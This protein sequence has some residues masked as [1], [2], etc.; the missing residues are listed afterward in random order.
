[1][2][3]YDDQMTTRAARVVCSVGS[4]LSVGS[5][6]V[7]CWPPSVMTLC[8]RQWRGGLSHSYNRVV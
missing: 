6:A 2:L 1:V 8:C 5:L 3:V 7:S 4:W